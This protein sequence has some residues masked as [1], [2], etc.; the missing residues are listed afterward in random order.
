MSAPATTPPADASHEQ[1][2]VVLLDDERA[3]LELLGESLR[4]SLACPVV[5]FT[6]PQRALD[7]L[8][9]LKVGMI[10]TDFQMPGLNGMEFIEKAQK[11]CPGIPVVMITAILDDFTKE[12]WAKMPALKAIIRKPFRWPQL[13]EQISRYWP[14]AT[15]APFMAGGR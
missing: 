13:A 8:P 4:G 9:S 6:N 5:G 15:T 11:V 1:R 14:S 3:Y 7:T 12:Q 10:I 2:C